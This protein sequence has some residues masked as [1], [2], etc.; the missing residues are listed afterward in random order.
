MCESVLI[1]FATALVYHIF[2]PMS[3]ADGFFLPTLFILC[4]IIH[5]YTMFINN[6]I[7]VHKIYP[8]NLDFLP[9]YVL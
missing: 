3:R 7:F 5:I 1:P 9:Y 6:G 2:A 4:A 8:N